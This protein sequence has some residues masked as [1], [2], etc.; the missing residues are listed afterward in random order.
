MVVPSASRVAR[1]VFTRGPRAAWLGDAWQSRPPPRP[2]LS[3]G[4]RFT[5]LWRVPEGEV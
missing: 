3:A 4:Q 5:L 1:L 2:A